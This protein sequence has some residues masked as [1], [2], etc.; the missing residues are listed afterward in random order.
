MI[1]PNFKLGQ[2]RHGRKIDEVVFAASNSYV[3]PTGT[4]HLSVEMWGGGGGGSPGRGALS[5]KRSGGGGGSGAYTYVVLIEDFKKEDIVT[6]TVGDAGVGSTSATTNGG[7]GTA[8]SL[9][10]YERGE[11]I[12]VTYTN[13]NAGGGQGGQYPRIN[14]NATGGTGGLTN[15]G[16]APSSNGN[17]G[18]DGTN[19]T[20]CASGGDGVNPS[21]SDPDGAI[22]LGGVCSLGDVAA[23]GGSGVGRGASGGGGGASGSS[24]FNGGSGASGELVI[25]AYGYYPPVPTEG[26]L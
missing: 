11:D 9:D 17:T 21:F 20:V 2:T 15:G 26:L 16:I 8:T 10:T 6:F 1:I 5:P 25:K 4:T 3:I 18:A 14:V 22:G 23:A 12:L 19:N 13:K 24:L 7:D